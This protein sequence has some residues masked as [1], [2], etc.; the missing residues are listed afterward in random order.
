MKPGPR[1][2]WGSIFRKLRTQFIAGIIVIVP[3]GVT[4]LIFVWIF[5]SIDNILQPVLTLALGRRIIGAGFVVTI[6]LIY[7]AGVIVSNVVGKELL[8]WI[9][10]AVGRVP[11]VR[12]IYQG[13]KQIVDSFSAPRKTGFMQVVLIEFPKQGMKTFGFITNEIA[14]KSGKKLFSVF[15]PTAPNPVSGFLEVVGEDEVIRTDIS[16]DDALKMIVSAGRMQTQKVGE[17]LSLEG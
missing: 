6:I 4:I 9:E 12:Q 11:V 5:N 8:R 7:L 16:V 17:R 15:I 13:V 2:P 14:G 3:I 1:I 10:S